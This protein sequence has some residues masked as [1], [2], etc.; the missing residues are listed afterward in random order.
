MKQILLD[1]GL[2]NQTVEIDEPT[3]IYGVF[4]GR[5]S[6]QLKSHINV[7]H[8]KPNLTSLTIVKAILFDSSVFNFTGNLVIN[9]GARNTD[10]YLKAS[11]LM[12]SERAR[13]TAVPSLEIMENNVKG[14]HGATVSKLDPEEIFYLRAKGLSLEN[15]TSLLL[16]GFLNEISSKIVD[17]ELNLQLAHEIKKISH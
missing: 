14:G 10:T 4:V 2:E 11:V 9:Q 17:P 1:L 3:E 7:V 16:H 5:D 12:L 15:A 8:N 13:A 6:Q